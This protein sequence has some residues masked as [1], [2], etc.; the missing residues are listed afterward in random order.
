[1]NTL[2]R[3]RQFNFRVNSDLLN[4]AKEVLEK[5][6]MS[7]SDALNLFV[8]QIATSETLPIQTQKEREAEI[9]LSELTAELDKGYQDILAGRTKPAREALTKYGL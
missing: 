6:N 5:E 7:L 3:D 1:M 8:E 9:F 4:H 2:K